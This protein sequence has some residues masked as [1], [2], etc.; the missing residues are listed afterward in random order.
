MPSILQGPGAL[1]NKHRAISSDKPET[2]PQEPETHCFCCPSSATPTRSTLINSAARHPSSHPPFDQSLSLA[3]EPHAAS[4]LHCTAVRCAALRYNSIKYCE[5]GSRTRST[6]AAH[7]P[8]SF[9]P[10]SPRPI[11]PLGIVPPVLHPKKQKHL[12]LW[13]GLCPRASTSALSSALL[14]SP[15]A[16]DS[17]RCTRCTR[18]PRY[19]PIRPHYRRR[20]LV[21]DF[22]PFWLL[23]PGSYRVPHRGTHGTCFSHDHPAPLPSSH[24][25]PPSPPNVPVHAPVLPSPGVI[26]LAS[27]TVYMC[28]VLNLRHTWAAHAVAVH[29]IHDT[30]FLRFGLA[31]D[32]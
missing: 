27:L 13:V 30:T 18:Y 1:R 28:S 26:S 19:P 5:T 3:P 8:G 11:P 7:L 15:A 6:P 14:P 10:S 20:C 16:F 9:L 31:P 32:S 23:G 2:R 22:G 12:S 17:T 24:R 4:Q 21:P 25:A 29:A